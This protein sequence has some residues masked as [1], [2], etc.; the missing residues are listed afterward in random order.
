M[1]ALGDL[2]NSILGKPQKAFLTVHKVTGYAKANKKGKMNVLP[3]ERAADML[4]KG[5][6]GMIPL[7]AASHKMEVQYNPSSI[8]FQASVKPI[9]FQGMQKNFHSD[10]PSQLSAPAS[11]IMSTELIFDDVNLKDAFMADKLRVS[12]GDVVSAVSGVLKNVLGDGYT[13]QPQ[14][15]GLIATTMH[16]LCRRVTFSWAD[17]SFTG[18]VSEVQARYTMFSVSGKPIRSVV[19]LGIRQAVDDDS[20]DIKWGKAFD[21]AFGSGLLDTVTG[22]KGIAGQAGNLI[23]VRF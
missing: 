17:M 11:I 12:A 5:V 20:D 7:G 15:N 14:T 22:G 9:K 2:G 8:T 10:I 1:G 4:T 6:S 13:V 21:D 23:N 16:P 18:D 19:K 3:A